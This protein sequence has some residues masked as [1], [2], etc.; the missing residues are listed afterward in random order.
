MDENSTV[1]I[2]QF[3]R[4]Y[5]ITKLLELKLNEIVQKSSGRKHQDRIAERGHF[6]VTYSQIGSYMDAVC[7]HRK[8]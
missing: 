6:S 5:V 4:K 2:Q 7:A 3:T 1:R 8:V